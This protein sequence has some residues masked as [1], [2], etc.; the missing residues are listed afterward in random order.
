MQNLL[1]DLKELLQQDER[2]VVDGKLLK[3]KI[4]ELALQL[5]PALIKMLLTHESIKRHFFQD[6]EG[7]MV[8]DKIKFQKFVSNKA[9]LPDSYTSFKNRI[10]LTVED[11]FIKENKDVVL[12]WPYKDCVLEGGQT[13]EEQSIEEV[14]WNKTLAPDE[15]DRLLDP[16]VFTNFKRYTSK[17]TEQIKELSKNENLIIKGNNL[18][19][20]HSLKPI[21]SNSVKLIYIDPPYNTGSDSFRYNDK[22]N[23]SSWLTFMKNRLEVAKE[24]LSD[25]G[26]IW[27]NIDDDESHYLKVLMDEVFGRENFVANVVWKKKYSPQNDAKYFSDMHDHILVYG[28]NKDVLKLNLIP[29]TAEANKRYKN[30]DNDPRG[31]WKSSDFSVKTYSAN[32]DFPITTPSGRVVNPPKSRSWRTSRE[33]YEELLA[34]NRIYFGV[35][36]DATPSIKRFLSEVQQGTPPQTIW[37]YSEVGHNQDARK[38]IL[39]LLDDADFA[40]PKPEKLLQRIIHISTN[41]DDIVLDFFA[42]SGTTAAV[43]MKMRRR[44]IICEQMD[45]IDTVTVPRIQKVIQGEQGGISTDVNWTGG[46]SFV[47]TELKKLNS[48]IIDLIEEAK[49]EDDLA[50]AFDVISKKGFVSYKV[51]IKDI[52]TKS[53]SFNELSFE[54]KQRFL[55]EILDKNQLYLN[56]S[57]IEDEDYQVSQQDKNLNH[58]FYKS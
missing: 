29:R 58:A 54:D 21:Y 32:Y 1:D 13:K 18:L 43:A 31:P 12:A 57:E 33:K 17:G 5:D 38:E 50:R 20:L 47:Y 39:A 55:I 48:H 7:V 40:T 53:N 37:D 8:F 35:N 25:N 9:F 10:G 4:I 36:D 56:F 11:D 44:F 24:L 26:S 14:F 51:D 42:G 45:Y 34:D 30:P 28:K 3:N 49:N 6:V 15:I 52:D 46:G 2:L 16:K 27:I 22:F 19:A 41:E 23:H